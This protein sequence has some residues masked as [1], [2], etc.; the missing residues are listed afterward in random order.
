MA[1]I[2]VPERKLITNPSLA[3]RA[4]AFIN[5]LKHTK[6]EWHGQPFNLLPWQETI[7]RDVFGTV[8]EWCCPQRRPRTPRHREGSQPGARCMAKP[9]RRQQQRREDRRARRGHEIYPHQYFT[10]AGAVFGNTKIPDQRNSED[11]PRTTSHG[12]RFGK[13]LVF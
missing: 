1:E 6:G 2:I 5:A 8:K 12:W 10:G 7:I 4:V 3:D 13:V 11:F 9:V